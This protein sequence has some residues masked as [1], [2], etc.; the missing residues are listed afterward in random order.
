[1]NRKYLPAT[2]AA[3]MV[4]LFLLL[5]PPTTAAQGKRPPAIPP[6]PEHSWGAPPGE[7]IFDTPYAPP[8]LYHPPPGYPGRPP[9][10]HYPGYP[11]YFYPHYPPHPGYYQRETPWYEAPPPLPAG[12]VYLLV[13]PVQA[14]ATINDYPLQRHPDLSYQL[15]LLPGE[16]RLQV[17]AEGYQP[18]QRQLRIQ[19]GER[20]Q[21]TISLERITKP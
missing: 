10:Y 21:L 16:Y 13:E 7:V 19:G 12:R 20:L 1:M 14:Q 17:T 8:Y 6:Q 5:T 9:Y 3:A 18:V 15:A 2:F 11:P 4:T